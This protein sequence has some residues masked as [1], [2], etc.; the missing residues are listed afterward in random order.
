MSSFDSV[1]VMHKRQIVK[2]L[3]IEIIVDDEDNDKL[4]ENDNDEP[5]IRIPDFL[6]R[7]H[8]GS[9]IKK[10]LKLSE[11][12]YR[13]FL[14]TKEKNLIQ[15][16]KKMLESFLQNDI[17]LKEIE[18]ICIKSQLSKDLSDCSERTHHGMPLIFRIK[19]SLES[20]LRLE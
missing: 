18:T 15:D 9:I 7:I 14:S 12:I 11:K 10:R 3:D 16:I 19:R 1:K 17:S 6:N 13:K 20:V 8:A 4:D 5:S 2:L